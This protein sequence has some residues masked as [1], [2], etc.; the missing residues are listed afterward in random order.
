LIVYFS[1]FGTFCLLSSVPPERGILLFNLYLLDLKSEHYDLGIIC[2][3]V[4]I[5]VQNW[6][7]G[8]ASRKEVFP[9]LYKSFGHCFED[10]YLTLVAWV[11]QLEMWTFTKFCPYFFV[12]TKFFLSLTAIYLLLILTSARGISPL[13]LLDWKNLF[14]TQFLAC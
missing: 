3:V 5:Y 1:I 6:P 8:T 12:F 4:Y 7:R 9:I 10:F 11:T 2:D 13:L 14:Q